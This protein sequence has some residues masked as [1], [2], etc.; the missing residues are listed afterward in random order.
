MKPLTLSLIAAA[1]IVGGA[2]TYLA[3]RPASSPAVSG[4][5]TQ[6][7]ENVTVVDG[8]QVIDLTAKGG[9]SPE[10]SVAKAGIPTVLRVSTKGTFDCSSAIRIPSMNISK[11]L[12]QS[13]VTE[14]DLGSP[15][16]GTLQ[17]TCGMGMYPFAIEF[18]G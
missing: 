9:Y 16:L 13:G 4:A 18:K 11:N 7:I 1:V 10:Q 2:L 17:G 12:P 5:G 6:P 15:Q 14:I 3:V 8:R